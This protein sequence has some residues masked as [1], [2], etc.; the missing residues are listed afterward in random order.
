MSIFKI[1]ILII[2]I[3]LFYGAFMTFWSFLE[4]VSCII[5][6]CINCITEEKA[7]PLCSLSI[8]SSSTSEPQ[9]ADSREV[10]EAS[11][12]RRGK[13]DDCMRKPQTFNTLTVWV[14]ASTAVD[15]GDIPWHFTARRTR[16]RCMQ[17]PKCKRRIRVRNI[18]PEN[19]NRRAVW[20]LHE[21]R[22]I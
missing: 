15:N 9:V 16:F 19:H 11:G 8:S 17:S 14:I 2:I 6:N 21:G 1:I 12:A 22:E 5:I 4:L 3:K 20:P 7:R 10:E 18:G 13:M